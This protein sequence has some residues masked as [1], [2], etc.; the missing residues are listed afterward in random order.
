MRFTLHLL[1]AMALA[2][3]ALSDTAR[4]QTTP[5][6]PAGPVYVATDLGK[7]VTDVPM[8]RPRPD[9]APQTASN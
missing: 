9:I 1:L 5:P 4:A 2:P 8:P 6:P 3:V 7:I